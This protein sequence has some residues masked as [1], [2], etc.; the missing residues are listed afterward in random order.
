MPVYRHYPSSSVSAPVNADRSVPTLLSLSTM[1]R[2]RQV[3][4]AYVELG[5]P[6]SLHLAFLHRSCVRARGA[7]SRVD[8]ALCACGIQYAGRLARKCHRP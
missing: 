5:L 4:P 8:Y 2:E 6:W 3:N 1:G 7:R